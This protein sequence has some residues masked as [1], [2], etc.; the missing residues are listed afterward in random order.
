MMEYESKLKQQLSR[1]NELLRGLQ[2]LSRQMIRQTDK[3]ELLQEILRQAMQ[4]LN[5][6]NGAISLVEPEG[7]MLRLYYGLGLHAGRIGTLGKVTEG[8][9]G[10]VWRSGRIQIVEDYRIWQQRLPIKELSRMTT[11]IMAPLK[12]EGKISGMLQISWN[13][14]VYLLR[15]EELRVLDQFIA[16]ASVALEN[17]TLFQKAREE[18]RERRQAETALKREQ[19]FSH[20]VIDSIPG[21]FYV[22]DEEGRLVQW[23]RQHELF[24]GCSAEQIRGKGMLDW[25][26]GNEEARRAIAATAAK[27]MQGE[28]AA[29]KVKIGRKNGSKVMMYFTAQGLI[30]DDKRYI[31]GVGTDITKIEEAEAA[32]RSLNE[33]L[34][35]KV[36]ER[37]Q[38]LNGLNQELTAMNEE[39]TAMNQE[40]TAMNESLLHANDL[41]Q[42]EVAERQKAEQELKAS[43]ERQKDMQEY[44]VQ[45]EKMAALGSLVAG[46]AHEV[47]TPVGV[48]V[49]AAS[50]LH[51]ITRDFLQ[52]CN[53][54][55][56]RRSDLTEYLSE[57]AE[58]AEI[59]LK[60]LERAGT[61]IKSFKQVSAD[62]SSEGRRVFKVKEYLGEI[63]LSMNPKLKKTQ[64]HIGIEC[65]ENLEID[66][67]PGA[68]AQV[69]TNLVMNSLSHAYVPGDEGRLSIKLSVSADMVEMVYSDDG[70]G[71]DPKILPRIFDPFF[72]TKRGAGGTGLGLAVVYNIIVQQFG[73][74]ITCDSRLGQGTT[75][76]IRFPLR[77]R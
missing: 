9:A 72:T 61:L 69:I 70:C 19:S 7:E 2:R 52:L 38:E 37:T 28:F 32:L 76:T 71:I 51:Q 68:F 21:L 27:A 30:M 36:A 60:N 26:E 47:N 5:A 12:V 11:T 53:T 13:D 43:L 49:T 35:G 64:H 73:G 48:G 65:D 3:N 66:G 75:F 15:G 57:A 45:S 40:L 14:K 67:Y 50:H 55:S 44:L 41:L 33:L 23:N 25:Y 59:L 17:A 77:G 20:A 4:F 74:T 46:V 29:T 58:A 62:Q 8:L 56:P 22:Y 24:T 63:L 18:L 6:S 54:G 42:A 31:V 34:E 10:E 1:E 16:M 39:M